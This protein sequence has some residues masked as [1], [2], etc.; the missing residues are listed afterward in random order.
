MMI[1]EKAAALAG[2]SCI[3]PYVWV[4]MKRADMHFKPPL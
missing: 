3:Y 1:M 4:Q 2:M